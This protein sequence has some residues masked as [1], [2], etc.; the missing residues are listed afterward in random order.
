MQMFTSILEVIVAIIH[1]AHLLCD[2]KLYKVRNERF[3]FQ[4]YMNLLRNSELL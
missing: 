2:Q 3:F 4:S 1:N